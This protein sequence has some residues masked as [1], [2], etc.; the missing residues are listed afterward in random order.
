MLSAELPGPV[1]WNIDLSDSSIPMCCMVG[2]KF[3]NLSELSSSSLFPGENDIY[4]LF[5]SDEI[6]HTL[7]EELGERTE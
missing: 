5:I 7:E 1:S 3:L 4:L 2:T 6:Y